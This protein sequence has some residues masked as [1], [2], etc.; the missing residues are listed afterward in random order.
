MP[1]GF[2][3]CLVHKCTHGK[4]FLAMWGVLA[5]YFSCAMVRLMIVLAPCA[6]I[7]GAIGCSYILRKVTKSLRVWILADNSK[8]PKYKIVPDVAIVCL[9]VLLISM[10]RTVIHSCRIGAES[11]QS[12]SIVFGGGRGSSRFIKDDMREAYYW[13]KQNTD[14]DAKVMSWWDYGY[15]ITGMANRTTIVD[16][17]TWNN[18]HI[19]T[20]GRAMASDEK[21]AHQVARSLDA[22]YVLVMFGGYTHHYTDDISKFLWMVRIAGGVYPEIKESNYKNPYYSIDNNLS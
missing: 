12:P 8:G 11:Y 1:V 3:Y 19:A 17:N 21:T 15:Q 2:Y 6:C 22:K 18:T 13:L 10:G 5:T 7:L 16:N 20:V 9:I 4:L 14:K